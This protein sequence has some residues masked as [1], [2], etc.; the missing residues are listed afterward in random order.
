MTGLN[1]KKGKTFNA[2]IYIAGDLTVIKHVCREFTDIGGCVSV[3]PT[4]FIYTGGSETGARVGLINYQRFPAEPNAVTSRA[5]RLARKLI[6][7]CHQKSAS[8]VTTE[9]T[10]YMNDVGKDTE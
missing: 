8:V 2:D 4:E 9:A 1:I 3:T 7:R 6:K 10:Y 5:L